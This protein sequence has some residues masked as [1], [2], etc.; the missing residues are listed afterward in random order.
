MA[1]WASGIHGPHGQVEEFDYNWDDTGQGGV[2]QGS[3]L[4]ISKRGTV[5]I[6][7]SILQLVALSSP[8]GVRAPCSTRV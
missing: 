7:F 1:L 3:H 5:K 2:S 6:C 4:V 8:C